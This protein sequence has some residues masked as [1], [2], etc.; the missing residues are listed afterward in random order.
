M[1]QILIGILLSYHVIESM[2]LPQQSSCGVPIIPPRLN[3]TN[4]KIVNGYSALAHSWPWQVSLRRY[5]VN[6]RKVSA[7]FCAGNLFYF[8]YF[9]LAIKKKF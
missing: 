4:L 9:K 1:A 5:F 2:T 6:S 8:Y 7:H 3:R